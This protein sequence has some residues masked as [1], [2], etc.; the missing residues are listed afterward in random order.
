MAELFY[1]DIDNAPGG[2]GSLLDGYASVQEAFDDR[3]IATGGSQCAI[4][5]RA[6]I[7]NV[8]GPIDTTTFGNTSIYNPV[9][10]VGVDSA[11]NYIQGDLSAKP[12]IDV[13]TGQFF[14]QHHTVW[15]G[16]YFVAASDQT[17]YSTTG[18]DAGV[19]VD[20]HFTGGYQQTNAILLLD[21]YST[22]ANCS[23]LSGGRLIEVGAGGDSCNIFGC[24]FSGASPLT[25]DHPMVRLHRGTITHCAFDFSSSFVDYNGKFIETFGDNCYVGHCSFDANR[26]SGGNTFYG[27]NERSI[28]GTPVIAN[29]VFKNFKD[30]N[31]TPI[32]LEVQGKGICHHNTHYNCIRQYG[33]NTPLWEYAVENVGS[34]PLVDNTFVPNDVGGVYSPYPINLPGTSI[35]IGHARGAMGIP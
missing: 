34:D 5:K 35:A 15:Q 7:V 9:S 13:T 19:F 30:T 10:F 20:C 26:K 6:G 23:F 11:G 27:I 22:V 29:C 4:I 24:W 14:S 8:I 28:G 18:R 33:T 17:L 21:D 3:T 32:N 1:V 12:R 2:D 16:L 31:T 25:G